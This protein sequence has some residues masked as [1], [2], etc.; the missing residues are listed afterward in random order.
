MRWPN[1]KT[2]LLIFSYPVSYLLKRVVDG[3]PLLLTNGERVRLIGVDT[4]EVRE[5]GKLYQDAQRSGRDIKT[6]KALGGE[7]NGIQRV[8]AGQEANKAGL[9]DHKP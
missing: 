7:G 4:P 5:S 2:F 1:R 9:F 3:D 8:I 6:I